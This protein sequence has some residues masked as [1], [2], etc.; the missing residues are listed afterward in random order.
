MAE[1][2]KK[3][4]SIRE[5]LCNT[6]IKNVCF[7]PSL[8]MFLL[9]LLIYFV[10]SVHSGRRRPLHAGPDV[11]GR[12]AGHV[13]SATYSPKHEQISVSLRTRLRQ[14]VRLQPAHVVNHWYLWNLKFFYCSNPEAILFWLLK[15]V[16]CLLLRPDHVMGMDGSMGPPGSQNS[17]GPSN[18]EG[19]MYSPSRYPSQQR[20]AL[21]ST[22]LRLSNWK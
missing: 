9:I 7:S 3:N 21:V 6:D 15:C 11:W 19:S 14:E 2:I 16:F 10:P 13:R 20:S 12:D 17:M 22:C 4:W 1:G 5:A 8:R 18:S